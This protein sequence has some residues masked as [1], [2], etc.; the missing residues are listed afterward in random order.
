[1]E[2][3]QIILCCLRFFLR[4]LQT[5]LLLIVVVAAFSISGTMMMNVFHK[6]GQVSLMR[7]LGMSQ[8]NI[9]TFLNAWECD[10]FIGNRLWYESWSGDL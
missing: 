8:E 3:H 4:S 5:I 2:S 7:S 9:S 10:R 6:R 1:M